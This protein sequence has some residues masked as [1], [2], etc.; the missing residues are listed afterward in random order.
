MMNPSEIP[1]VRHSRSDIRTAPPPGPGDGWS[2]GRAS[3]VAGVGLLVMS[4][5]GAFANFAVVVRLVAPGDAAT[6]AANIL[7]A[8][9]MFHLGV[10]GWVLIVL[11]DVV[12]AWGL[13]RVF[14]PA[15]AAVSLLAAWFRLV[16]AGVLLVAVSHLAA[17]VQ[18]LGEGAYAGVFDGPQQQVLALSE[19]T[20]FTDTYDLALVLFGVHLLLLGYLA[21]RSGYVPKLL[22]ALLAL[23]GAGYV[24]DSLVAV[25]ALDFPVT[26][27]VFTFL[28]EFLLALWLVI[29]GRRLTLVDAGGPA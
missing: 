19:T 4:V 5:L 23:A 13:F 16:Y 28:G 20:A 18:I 3:V 8:E 15:S 14:R 17:A 1:S 24:F 6:T 12:V 2:I 11:L 25:L 22:G 26:V 21:W 10:V 9:A 7:G 27:S 29:R